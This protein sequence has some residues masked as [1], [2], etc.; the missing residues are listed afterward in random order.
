MMK[1]SFRQTRVNRVKPREGET[2]VY[3]INIYEGY[4]IVLLIVHRFI[5]LQIFKT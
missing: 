1:R 4:D 3:D 5:S 2:F